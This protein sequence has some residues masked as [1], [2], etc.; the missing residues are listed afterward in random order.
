MEALDIPAGGTLPA[1]P[2]SRPTPGPAPA[3]GRPFSPQTAQA[4]VDATI[5]LLAEHPLSEISIDDIAARARVSKA[6][7]YRRWPTKGTL[8]FDAFMTEFLDRQ[9]PPDTGRLEDDLLTALRNW[10][11]TVDGTTAG[12]T[13]RGLIA[14]VQRDPALAD[15]WRDRFVDPVRAR[16]LTMTDRAIAR[17]E[18][19]PEAD[20]NLVLD[21]LFGPAY[22]RLLQHHLPLDDAFITG[23]VTAIAAAIRAGVF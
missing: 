12:R 21:L 7:I 17:G 14:E 10:V 6:S 19:R 20:A 13:L 18:L 22:H 23:V 4:I 3:R 2:S 5:G 8:A 15:A 1:A 11:R 9:P 16:H